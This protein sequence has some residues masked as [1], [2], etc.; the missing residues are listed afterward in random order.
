ME[1]LEIQRVDNNYKPVSLDF[2][3]VHITLGI[4]SSLF[5][6]SIIPGVLENTSPQGEYTLNFN[7][8]NHENTVL[9]NS[10]NVNKLIELDSYGVKMVE[11]ASTG[12]RFSY[13]K[14]EREVTVMSYSSVQTE[15][16]VTMT[17]KLIMHQ[18]KVENIGFYGGLFSGIAMLTMPLFYNIQWQATIPTTLLFLSLPMFTFIRK[19]LKEDN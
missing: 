12:L 3:G 18:N 7:K 2:K 5:A 9:I 10:T 13:E 4:V 19:K 15:E 11:T 6:P 16:D 8:E 1:T 17:N 14:A